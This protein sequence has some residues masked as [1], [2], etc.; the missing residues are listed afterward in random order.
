[1]SWDWDSASLAAVGAFLATRGLVNGP[2]TPH[3]IGDGH[4]NL[5]GLV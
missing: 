4:W 1:M 2:L 5:T 3:R